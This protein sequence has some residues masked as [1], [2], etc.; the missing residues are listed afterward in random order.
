MVQPT[1]VTDDVGQRTLYVINQLFG[2][3]P[4]VKEAARESPEELAQLPVHVF[5]DPPR[6]KFPCHTKAAAWLS[7]AYFQYARANYSTVEAQRVQVGIKKYADYWGI[8]PA[9]D[10]FNRSFAKAAVFAGH[11]LKDEDYAL[12]VK[13]DSGE[14]IRRM[15]M[16]NAASVKAAGEYLYA[17]R[18][19]YPLAWRKA[20]A[21]RILGRAAGSNGEKQAE[22]TRFAPETEDYLLRA[23][24]Q[25]VNHPQWIAEQL[26]NRTYMLTR[27]HAEHQIKLAETAIVLRNMERCSQIQLEKLAEALDMLDRETGLYQHYADGVPMPEEVCFN[28]L[29]KEA[30]A[31]VANQVV[32]QTG[33][34]YQLAD[35]A[36]LPIEKVAAVLGEEVAQ[37]LKNAQGQL[38]ITKLAEIAP[39]LPRPDAKLL[40]RMLFE[41]KSAEAKPGLLPLLKEARL[42]FKRA[43]ELKPAQMALELAAALNQTPAPGR[44]HVVVESGGGGIP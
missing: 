13:L 36:R 31:F 21:R 33:S 7:N 30:E 1:D 16:P 11:D 6:R 17:N 34:I 40:E 29:A 19:Q 44:P 23:A 8:G 9:V 15:P 18:F 38:D 39:T 43:S 10:E 42:K 27:K 41:T 37:Q 22:Q 14:T 32:L 35:F 12:V 3:P 5:A 2:L 25:G 20:A 26:A 4:F 28:V 24:G